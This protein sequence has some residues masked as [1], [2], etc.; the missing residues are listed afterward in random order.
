MTKYE[1]TDEEAQY[2]LDKALNNETTMEQIWLSIDI[3][4]EMKGFK[5]QK[6][7]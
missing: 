6:E 5:K 2:I 7:E 1:V 3:F 4:A